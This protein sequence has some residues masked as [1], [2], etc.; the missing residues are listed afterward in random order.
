MF[1]NT[2]YFS[3]EKLYLDHKLQNLILLAQNQNL[4]ELIV[5][6]NSCKCMPLQSNLK[7]HFKT[8]FC[9]GTQ[10]FHMVSN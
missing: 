1:K 6:R 2:L 10:Q 7:L 3:L 8:F 4:L 5:L 9:T